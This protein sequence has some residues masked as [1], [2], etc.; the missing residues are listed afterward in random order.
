LAASRL[1]AGPITETPPVGTGSAID[2]SPVLAEPAPRDAKNP[3][4]C[5]TIARVTGVP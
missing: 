4:P 1:E 5:D 2:T 3:N